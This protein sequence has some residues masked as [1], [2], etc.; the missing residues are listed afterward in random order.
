MVNHAQL[1]GR[2][3]GDVLVPTYNWSKFFDEHFKRTA[4]ADIK[5][6]HYFHFDASSPGVV[7]V[8]DTCDAPKK[9]ISVLKDP[10]WRPPPSAL[11]EVIIP[12]GLSLERQ[13]YLFEKIREFCNPDVR[14]TVCPQPPGAPRSNEE[15]HVLQQLPPR[16]HD[17]RD[18]HEHTKY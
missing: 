13:L 4:F 6:H 12:A 11:P 8:Q 18:S 1:V 9:A 15:T 10:S 16:F 5:S 14:D 7:H 17:K 3:N 2:E